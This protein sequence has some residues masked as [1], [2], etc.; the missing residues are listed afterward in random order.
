MAEP[1]EADAK[2]SLVDPL[3]WQPGMRLWVAAH[4]TTPS[5]LPRLDYRQALLSRRRLRNS[6][7][8]SRTEQRG[9]PTDLDAGGSAAVPE[10]SHGRF[11]PN[12]TVAIRTGLAL[13]A[14]VDDLSSGKDW[15]SHASTAISLPRET[16]IGS[17]PSKKAALEN[18]CR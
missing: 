3:C 2:G 6:G 17:M 14:R 13:F 16:V 11:T 4:V 7:Q 9:R 12:L 10:A 8:A 5:R 15:I 18:G 1:H